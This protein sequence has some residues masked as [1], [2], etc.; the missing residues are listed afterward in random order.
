MVEFYSRGGYQSMLYFETFKETIESLRMPFVT[1]D[2]FNNNFTV[3][4][5]IK[6]KGAIL[7]QSPTS[8]IN[9]V[10]IYARG[11]NFAC[12]SLYNLDQ[13]VS[14]DSYKKHISNLKLELSQATI[15]Y[16]P[17]SDLYR[18]ILCFNSPDGPYDLD[19]EVVTLTPFGQFDRV[20]KSEIKWEQEGF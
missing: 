6:G 8:P 12:V 3:E 4:V 9:N 5:G 14:S 19:P 2:H 20:S 7:K 18:T 16:L 13:I 1:Q 10:L 11:V 15:S 17:D